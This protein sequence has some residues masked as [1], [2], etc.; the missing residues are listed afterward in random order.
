MLALA[1]CGSDE[2]SSGG[3]ALT[4]VVD[5]RDGDT[6]EATT[7][8]TSTTLAL[9]GGGA[10]SGTD[11]TAPPATTAAPETT[12]T[13]LVTTTTEPPN[14][15]DC[16]V[17]VWRLRSQEFLD[18]IIATIPADIAGS[19]LQSWTHESG[20]Y[21]MT[22]GAD[23]SYLGERKA[24]TH[25]IS[26]AEGALITTI[27]STDPGTY[28]VDGNNISINDPGSPATV[29]L[30]FDDGSG[31]QSLPFGGTQ[32]VGADAVSGTGTFTCEG[33]VLS[34]TILDLPDAPPE[35]FTATWDRA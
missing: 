23:G 27:D 34:A 28:S 35:G 30:Q 22:L 20:E 29:T 25:R 18:A 17:G 15:G 12:T 33:D 13:E 31:P 7:S 16:L 26:T 5:E 9:V 10:S 24:W 11:T 4:T 8:T 19:G 21:L 32:T 2:D 6:A 3:A 14:P 1:A